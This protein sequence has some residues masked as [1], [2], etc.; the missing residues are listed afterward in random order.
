VFGL[1]TEPVGL[2]NTQ[3]AEV[4]YTGAADLASFEEVWRRV[5]VAAMSPDQSIRVAS[6]ADSTLITGSP[7]PARS[8]Q[9]RFFVRRV[10]FSMDRVSRDVH[11]VTR[12]CLYNLGA[13]WPVLHS[14]GP[15]IT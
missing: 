15:E 1:T 8:D 10:A 2:V 11:E 5:V 12:G 4:T 3:P 14:Q 13:T 9:R 7:V 6:S